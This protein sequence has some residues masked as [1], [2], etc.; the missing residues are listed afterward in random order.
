MRG[1]IILFISVWFD[2][3]FNIF[4]D[5]VASTWQLFI[6]LFG[7][8]GIIYIY[9][10]LENDVPLYFMLAAGTGLFYDLVLTNTGMMNLL[11]Y[12]LVAF[13]TA[14]VASY[15]KPHYLVNL[16]LTGFNVT[17]YLLTSYLLLVVYDVY[18][19]NIWAL[20]MGILG[21]YLLNLIYLTVLT[22]IDRRYQKK[23]KY[24]RF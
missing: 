4:I 10:Y 1:I 9:K 2:I 15:F 6:P 19:F 20:V 3:L 12:L 21:S 5:P 17:I 7:I 16:A 22:Y 14:I 18:L 13:I 8:T 11:L 23:H 24:R